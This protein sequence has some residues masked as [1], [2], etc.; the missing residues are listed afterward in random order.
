[1]L[2]CTE[3]PCTPYR[4]QCAPGKRLEPIHSRGLDHDFPR[5]PPL[6]WWLASRLKGGEPP[7]GQWSCRSSW[8]NM[9]LHLVRVKS[10]CGSQDEYPLFAPPPFA[11]ESIISLTGPADSGTQEL[12]GVLTSPRIQPVHYR[13]DCP[14]APGLQSS[15]QPGHLKASYY[16]QHWM[17]G[18]TSRVC[19]FDYY[20]FVILIFLPFY[21][22]PPIFFFTHVP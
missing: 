11:F 20:V 6:I 3:V 9:A 5:L 17:V 14:M 7:A 21:L 8:F 13:Q 19:G 15:I 12:S 18:A 4:D 10:Q 2:L 16:H 22:F 1:M